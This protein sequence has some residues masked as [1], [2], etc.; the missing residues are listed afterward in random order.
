[1]HTNVDGA[2]LLIKEKIKNAP[3]LPEL[4]LHI[5]FAQKSGRETKTVFT[6]GQISKAQQVF[7]NY[8]Q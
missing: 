4:G 3:L 2:Y 1:M 6:D 7:Y 8:K 5:K